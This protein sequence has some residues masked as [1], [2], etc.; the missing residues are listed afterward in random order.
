MTAC[1]DEP[2]D[3]IVS[4]RPGSDIQEA[5]DKASSGAKFLFEPGIYRQQRL[6]PKDR[7]EFIGKSGTII[8]GAILLT[9]WRKDT[10]ANIW[11][12]DGLPPQ[13]KPSGKCRRNVTMCRFREDLFVDGKLYARVGSKEELAAGKWH[14]ADGSAYL[15][16]DPA[17][18]TVEM[19]AGPIAFYGNAK[20]VVLKNLIIEKF[21][22]A[23]QRGAIDA[24]KGEAWKVI[25]VTLRWNH[26]VGLYMGPKMQVVGG[27]VV[28][29]GQLGIG[30]QPNDGL[31][32]GVEVAFNN[33]AGFSAGWEAGGTKFSRATNLVVRNNCVHSNIGPGLWTDIN[34][35][36][37]LYEGN[38]VFN[39]A[40]DGIKH[41]ISYKATIRDNIVAG[42]GYAFDN[43][44]WGSQILI[45]NSQDVE[46]LDNTVVV[47]TRGGN[48][49]SVINQER[50]TGKFGRFVAK[51][52]RVIGNTIIHL[53]DK[54]KNGIVSDV[55]E[56][57]FWANNSNKF[58]R[59]E[60]FGVTPDRKF[61]MLN[62]RTRRWPYLRDH[63]M[64]TEGKLVP[65]R[66]KFEKLTCDG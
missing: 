31:V 41:E 66:R 37:I 17:G 34:N 4:L 10:N 36:D 42:N 64:E 9:Q 14:Y 45:Q 46:V 33:Y 27:A 44:L 21:A 23:A 56:K 51:N 29:N 8:S 30:G 50:G 58:N 5:I 38:K 63:G 60:Y 43:W 26:G 47:G 22:T 3:G 61:W 52:N 57:E 59:N 12:A 24:R 65:L 54:G 18:K 11:I 39:N 1:A 7:Q 13:L 53:A 40:A 2:K 15:P 32:D 49:I 19:S 35:V 62:E 20:Q 48:G 16:I 28:H 6:R 55:D 25:D